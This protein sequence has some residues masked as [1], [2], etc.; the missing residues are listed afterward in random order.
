MAQGQTIGV[1]AT[2]LE[3][4]AALDSLVRGDTGERYQDFLITLA[5]ASRIETPT[6][7]DLARIGRGG[8]MNGSNVDLKS[9]HDA[10]AKM[11]KMKDGR[12]HP[13]HRAEHRS[14]WTP[15]PSLT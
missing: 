4:N 9:P 15:S 2:T 12:T 8:R 7:E 14:I 6:R 5:Q 1:D 3:A 13:A 11:T 10:D